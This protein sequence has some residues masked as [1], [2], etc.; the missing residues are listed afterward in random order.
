M[1]WQHVSSI[2]LGNW[3]QHT[4]CPSGPPSLNQDY[5]LYVV[6]TCNLFTNARYEESQIRLWVGGFTLIHMVHNA[7][8]Q[9]Y[10]LCWF[11]VPS[12]ICLQ[13]EVVEFIDEFLDED[14]PVLEGPPKHWKTNKRQCSPVMTLWLV[15]VFLPADPHPSCFLHFLFNALNFQLSGM[16]IQHSGKTIQG[17]WWWWWK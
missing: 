1:G 7:L 15:S 16:G 8:L 12:H 6:N 13:G 4:D 14:Y 9:Q 3:M 11:S 2:S 5:M 10:T 17:Q